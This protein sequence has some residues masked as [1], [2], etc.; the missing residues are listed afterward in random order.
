MKS[1]YLPEQRATLGISYTKICRNGLLLVLSVGIEAVHHQDTQRVYKRQ[2]DV[3]NSLF[4]VSFYS[5]KCFSE[6]SYS[7][8]N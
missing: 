7:V 3:H 2:L 1:H 4:S 8:S 5:S 6:G